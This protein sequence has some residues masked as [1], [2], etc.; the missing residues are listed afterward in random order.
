[1]CYELLSHADELSDVG[2]CIPGGRASAIKSHIWFR[3][4]ASGK[5]EM[6]QLF[7]T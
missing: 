2:F 3:M 6:Q 1:V 7:V 4:Q 5:T